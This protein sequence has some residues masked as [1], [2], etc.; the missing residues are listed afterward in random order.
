MT[1]TPI[2]I[3]DLILVM[4][5]MS[6]NF[7]S[8]LSNIEAMLLMRKRT[9]D[10]WSVVGDNTAGISTGAILILFIGNS[11]YDVD[12]NPRPDPPLCILAQTRF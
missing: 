8:L 2:S 5:T 9:G 7:V 10:E 12:P 3:V 4:T 6:R 1:L 11:T